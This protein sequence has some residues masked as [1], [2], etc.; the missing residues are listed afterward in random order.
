MV[1][2]NFGILKSFVLDNLIVSVIVIEIANATVIEKVWLLNNC[3]HYK[4]FNSLGLLSLNLRSMR[5]KKF[6]Y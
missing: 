5:I 2:S 6:S 1:L 4:V 3:T